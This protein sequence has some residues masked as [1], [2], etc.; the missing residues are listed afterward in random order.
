MLWSESP[1]MEIRNSQL[2]LWN[3]CIWRGRFKNSNYC[4]NKH[5]YKYNSCFIVTLLL[6]KL[7]LPLFIKTR[8]FLDDK[9]DT[10]AKWNW[11]LS[12]WA[13]NPWINNKNNKLIA[14]NTQM[15]LLSPLCVCVCVCVWLSHVRIFATPWTVAHQAPLSMGFSRQ[16][17]WSGLPCPSP[18]NTF[19]PTQYRHKIIFL[20]TDFANKWIVS[21]SLLLR[22]NNIHMKNVYSITYDEHELGPLYVMCLELAILLLHA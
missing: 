13:V 4:I 18:A 14:Q 22:R 20:L 2:L 21:L 19:V 7:I 1:K 12:S 8:E 17:H 9:C 11:L 6:S 3:H 16:E 15:F 10:T 5:K